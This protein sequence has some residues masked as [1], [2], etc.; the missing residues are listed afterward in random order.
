MRDAAENDK[1]FSVAGVLRKLGISTSGYYSWR[2]R[3]ESRSKARKKR[4]MDEIKTIHKE[5]HMVYGA[6]KIAH[7]LNERGVAVS[8]RTEV[9]PAQNKNNDQQRFL[10]NIARSVETRIQSRTSECG[11]VHRYHIYLD[12]KRRIRVPDMRN[13]PVF[14][15]DRGMDAKQ[16]NGGGGSAAKRQEGERKA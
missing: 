3:R 2:K 14:A 15:Q 7:V 13:G 10:I 8:Q 4:I 9:Y 11:M 5:S 16:D 12:R 1:S 6:P